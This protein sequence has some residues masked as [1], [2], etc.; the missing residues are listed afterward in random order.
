MGTPPGTPS[1]VTYEDVVLGYG[2]GVVLSGVDLQI[3]AGSYLG[4]VGPNGSGKTTF[5]RSV[6]GF[7]RPISGRIRRPSGRRIRI[8]YVPQRQSLDPIFPLRVRDVAVMGL[9]RE[10]GFMRRVQARH[11]RRVEEALEF[12]G[13][14]ELAEASYRDLSG[15]QQQRTLIARALASEPDLLVLDEPTNGMDL[16]GERNIMGLVDRLHAQGDRTVLMVSHRLHVVCRHVHDLALISEG[17]MV[18]G[19][20][21][22]MFTSERLSALYGIPVRVGRLEGERVLFAESG[23]EVTGR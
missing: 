11:R 22:E 9:Y 7:L 23:G 2:E 15:G 10:I 14:R 1:I 3:R 20:M 21:E 4:I 5:L 17:K 18:H 19:S 16:V 8:G 6:L 13:M 12:V